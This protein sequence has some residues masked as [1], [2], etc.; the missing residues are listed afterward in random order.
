MLLHCIVFKE[1]MNCIQ[2]PF[3]VC[4]LSAAVSMCCFVQK[5]GMLQHEL[6][7]DLKLLIFKVLFPVM[8]NPVVLSLEYF[9]CLNLKEIMSPNDARYST[10]CY[11]AYGDY[12]QCSQLIVYLLFVVIK[13]P[14]SENINFFLQ[15]DS[16]AKLCSRN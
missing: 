9:T 13:G 6:L 4:M 5:Y 8:M 16:V 11:R 10:E 2:G 3:Y 12:L 1:A 14:I 15:Q 7:A